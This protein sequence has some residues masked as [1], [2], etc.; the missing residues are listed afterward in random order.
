MTLK[1]K[2][3][4]EEN[5]GF[6]WCYILSQISK[7]TGGSSLLDVGAG[8]GYF[9]AIARTEFGLN[10]V[11][12]E[13]SKKEVEFAKDVCAVQL[14]NEDIRS[15]RDNYDIITSFNVIEHVEDPQTFL[16]SML[17]RLNP[18]GIM[19]ITTPNPTCIHTRVKGVENWNMVCPPHHVNLFSSKA[20]NILLENNGL[21][22]IKYET[23]STYINFVRNIDTKSLL[24]R[25]LFFHILRIFNLGADHCVLARRKGGKEAVI[26]L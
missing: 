2:V 3:E 18:G 13:I 26:G 11:G 12:I 10:A 1:T 24:L 8:N 22:A 23:L 4:I 7:V 17:Q 20:L 25:R 9:V 14:I 6:R 16:C 5:W 15:H 21:I 19:V